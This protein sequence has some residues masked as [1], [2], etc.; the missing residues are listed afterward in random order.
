MCYVLWSQWDIYPISCFWNNIQYYPSN[1]SK[2][3]ASGKTITGKLMGTENLTVILFRSCP[4]ICAVWDEHSIFLTQGKFDCELWATQKRLRVPCMGPEL[5]RLMNIS[6]VSPL[7]EFSCRLHHTEVLLC[8]VKRHL[9]CLTGWRCGHEV[10]AVSNEFLLE[11]DGRRSKR[12][13]VTGLDHPHRCLHAYQATAG[14]I[15]ERPICW[16]GRG[17]PTLWGGCL[18]VVLPV[19]DWYVYRVYHKWNLL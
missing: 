9:H 8:R 15:P 19:Y 2:F 17:F 16:A 13:G 7:W 18:L 5:A 6:G 3:L 10:G 1:V 12:C 4:A 11:A 14:A